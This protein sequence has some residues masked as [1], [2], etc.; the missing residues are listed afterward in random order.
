MPFSAIHFFI[1]HWRRSVFF[2]IFFSYSVQSACKMKCLL[3]IHTLIYVILNC[4]RSVYCIFLMKVY[5]RIYIRKSFYLFTFAVVFVNSQF[6]FYIISFEWI[7]LLFFLNLC[8]KLDEI[9]FFDD[10]A[11]F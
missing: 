10:N 11:I 4:R 1:E 3:Y 2:F 8:T 7:F 6:F 5:K 9:G